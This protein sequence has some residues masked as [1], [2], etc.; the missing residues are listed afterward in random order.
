MNR[1]RNSIR[2]IAAICAF[3]LCVQ[4][5]GY[6]PAQAQDTSTIESLEDSTSEPGVGEGEIEHDVLV[7][8]VD[9]TDRTGVAELEPLDLAELPLA[10]DPLGLKT[11]SDDLIVMDPPF[12]L[13]LLEQSNGFWRAELIPDEALLQSGLVSV[14]ISSNTEDNQYLDTEKKGTA[15]EMPKEQPAKYMEYNGARWTSVDT[16]P[17]YAQQLQELL[18]QGDVFSTANTSKAGSFDTNTKISKQE[19]IEK[20]AWFQMLPQQAEIVESQKPIYFDDL[21]LFER[22]TYQVNIRC[23]DGTIADYFCDFA[24]VPTNFDGASKSYHLDIGQVYLYISEQAGSLAAYAVAQA[25]KNGILSGTQ[26]EVEPND[27]FST[28]N[29][30]Y[31][32]DDM[33]GRIAPAYEMDY[34]KVVFSQG[35]TV[36]FWVGEMPTSFATAFVVFDA[37]QNAVAYCPNRFDAGY[38]A[39][40]I[41][42]LSVSPGTYY[43]GVHCPAQQTA[44]PTGTYYHLRVKQLTF[45]GS[46]GVTPDIHEPDDTKNAAWTMGLNS[47]IDTRNMHVSGNEDWLQFTLNETMG[48]WITLN[49]IPTGCDYD[50]A[51]YASNGT[52]LIYESNNGG[53]SSERIDTILSS[54]VYYLRV[55]SYSGASAQHY[56]L[57]IDAAAA[58]KPT[59]SIIAPAA[60][61]VYTLGS[62]GTAIVRVNANASNATTTTVQ[63]YKGTSLLKTWNANVYED[64]TVTSTGDYKVKVTATNTVG[65]TTQERAFSVQ[66]GATPQITIATPAAGAVFTLSGGAAAVRINASATNATTT[67][68]QLYRG[69]S[70]LKTWNANVN[71]DYSVTTAGDYKVKVTASNAAGTATLERAFIVQLGATPVIT[72]TSP[73]QQGQQYTMTGSSISINFMAGAPTATTMSMEVTKGSTVVKSW[74]AVSAT[75]LNN[76]HTFTQTGS[77]TLTVRATNANGTTTTTRTFEVLPGVSQIV[78]VSGTLKAN[79]PVHH[80]PNAPLSGAYVLGGITVRVSASTSTGTVFA[81]KELKTDATGTLNGTFDLTGSPYLSSPYTIKAE[82]VTDG[83]I[84][85]IRDDTL[86]T[87]SKLIHTQTDLSSINLG[88]TFSPSNTTEDFLGTLSIWR[89]IT[90]GHNFVEQQTGISLP[91][92]TVH[93]AKGWAH[94]SS[95]NILNIMLLKGADTDADHYDASVILHEYGHFVQAMYPGFGPRLDSIASHS[96]TR[97]IGGI[98]GEATALSEGWADFF[99]AAVLNGLTINNRIS[100]YYRDSKPASFFGSSL[101][102]PGTFQSDSFSIYYTIGADLFQRQTV[103]MDALRTEGNVGAVLWDLYDSVSDELFSRQYAGV[104]ITANDSLN[105]GFSSIVENMDSWGW[106]H[107]FYDAFIALDNG[108]L[109]DTWDLF[110]SRNI[111]RAGIH[112]LTG[113]DER[114]YSTCLTPRIENRSNLKILQGYGNI[115]GGE[116][117]AVHQWVIDGQGKTI[118]AG[119][120]TSYNYEGLSYGEHTAALRVWSHSSFVVGTQDGSV[121]AQKFYTQSTCTF[122]VEAGGNIQRRSV[123]TVQLPGVMPDEEAVF[124]K[125]ISFSEPLRLEIPFSYA[126]SDL[127]ITSGVHGA[128]EAINIYR[129]DGTLH[130]TLDYLAVD[131]PYVIEC[132]ESGIWAIEYVPPQA[133][134][135]Q[136]MSASLMATHRPHMEVRDYPD[137][138]KMASI[139]LQQPLGTGQTLNVEVVSDT[140]TSNQ[141][142]ASNQ[143]Q[144]VVLQQGW[145]QLTIAVQEGALRSKEL[146]HSVYCDTIPLTLTLP[147][148]TGSSISTTQADYELAIELSKPCGLVVNGS[149]VIM[150]TDKVGP[151]TVNLPLELQSGSNTIL[152]QAYDAVGNEQSRSIVINSQ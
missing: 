14:T 110:Y 20:A 81:Q 76:S 38:S 123:Y 139:T 58:S 120:P 96:F 67:T 97:P 64:Y 77:Y 143:Q 79:T 99:S 40:L 44:Y 12:T 142:F 100:N 150:H 16:V 19:L 114:G 57:Y 145:N 135:G 30:V 7:E 31:D 89:Y 21:M 26:Y 136:I 84:V 71:E 101:E 146:T 98:N 141:F 54:G 37:N 18:E 152:I 149:P 138:S 25:Q 63:L 1:M 125:S 66:A 111:H 6:F 151:F 11:A 108:L 115:S 70:L 80:G 33:Y 50:L 48:C 88:K 72:I 148:I 62:A 28:A 137:S 60:G 74:A 47:S 5:A 132:A 116:P 56:R 78:T 10:P 75:M 112:E 105:I 8:S 86:E 134:N 13:T 53:N 104:A 49:N 102:K 43:I 46:G 36:N 95:M 22:Y 83:S 91:K 133:A 131:S 92:E 119:A 17:A 140:G 52:S 103:H 32:D 61:A 126:N 113:A 69:T 23:T 130:E 34:Y 85:R 94:V 45:T 129:P 65:T 118:T 24:I 41:S 35:G 144:T 39:K 127:S 51:L 147:G 82:L 59:V 109:S 9:F 29:R 106:T 3:L 128:V 87:H 122:T 55:K 107:N 2:G 90:E 42:A 4:S 15:I 73:S 27:T 93:W 121:L 117:I 68:V 124:S